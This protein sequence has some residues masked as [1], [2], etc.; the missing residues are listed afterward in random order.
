MNIRAK[1]QLAASDPRNEQVSAAE[2]SEVYSILAQASKSGLFTTWR[3]EEKNAAIVLGFQEFW[4]SLREPE[5]GEWPQI[6]VAGQPLIDPDVVKLTDLPEGL[7]GKE[8]IALWN[9]RKATLEQIPGK[10]KQEL[11]SSGFEQMLRLALGHPSP[12][13]PLQDDLKT[14]RDDLNSPDSN[15]RD[16]A[17]NK[18]ETDLHM[19]VESFNR[20]IVIKAAN[21][22]TDPAKKP[23]ATQLAEV[24][25]LLTSARKLKHEYPKWIQEEAT[26]GLLTWQAIKAKLPLWRASTEYRQAWQQALRN[27]TRQPVI[28]PWLMGADDLQHVIPGDPA[29]DLW[30]ARYDQSVSL[31]D[32]IQAARESENDPT[33]ALNKIVKTSIGVELAD[34]KALDKDRQGLAKPSTIVWTS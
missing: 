16:E 12:G 21:E 14:L 18:I 5:V 4:F 33:V 34:L 10:L 11:E 15:V 7:A 31:H 19:S 27:R 26:A 28:D 13:D 25:A 30:K 20:L 9:E 17:T 29:F 6:P 22:Q 23:T 2:W 24:F 3:T 32:G 8:A 1:D